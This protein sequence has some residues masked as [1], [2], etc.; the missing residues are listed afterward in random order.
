M[1]GGDQPSY[2]LDSE[3]AL[4]DAYFTAPFPHPSY[5]LVDHLGAVRDK[6]VG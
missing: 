2:V 5:V 3:Y 4:R 1:A 6:F